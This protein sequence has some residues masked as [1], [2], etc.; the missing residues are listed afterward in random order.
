[1]RARV[2]VGCLLLSLAGCQSY[3]QLVM[4]NRQTG[5]T[6]DC[7]VP[8][9]NAPPAAFLVSRA[10]L[11]ACEAHGFRAIPNVPAPAGPPDI[12]TACSN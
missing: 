4:V 3:P 6:V 12:P 9:L 2:A 11:S 10:C 5:A 8:D 7:Q 1:M